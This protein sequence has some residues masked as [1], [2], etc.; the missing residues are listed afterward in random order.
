MADTL[1]PKASGLPPLPE[2][3][4]ALGRALEQLACTPVLLVALDFDGTLAPEV[5]HPAQARALPEA[6][7]A[8]LRLLN[9]PD[10]RVALIS[11]RTISSLEKVAMADLPDDAAVLL[12]G[13][14]G[15]E[16]RLDLLGSTVA[17][18]D[19]E[20]AALAMLGDTLG[21]VVDGLAGVWLEAKPVGFAMHTRLADE[22]V[23]R[24]ANERALHEVQARLGGLTVRSGKNV[25]EF[26]VRAATKAQ[27]IDRLRSYTGASAVFFAGDDLTDEDAFAVLGPSD[28]GVKIGDGQT[29]A[30]FR[31]PGPA[32]LAS[33]LAQL[34]DV[35]EEYLRK[36]PPAKS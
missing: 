35:R 10:T 5:D 11:G 30:G 2:T 22:Q 18:D 27:A 4:G 13:S 32:S 15:V 1:H 34:A 21:S 16:F 17:L 24:V 29:A 8:L 12:A 7:T 26:S 28:A 33:L 9:L 36:A 14:H 23:A 6:R 19:E 20:R 25:L 3:Q 31:L